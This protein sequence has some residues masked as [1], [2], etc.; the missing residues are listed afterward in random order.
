MKVGILTGGG[1]CPGLNAAIRAAAKKGFQLG[2]EIIGI[3]E[4]WKGLIEG[5]F[6][7][8]TNES[9]SGILHRGGTILGSSRTNPF[10]VEG[11]PEKILENF[12]K[13]G[14]DALIAIGGEDTLGVAYKLSKDIPIVGIP[15]TI[16]N[17]AGGTDFCI[18][19]YTAVQTTC[20][21]L[22][23][24]HPTAESH[25][26]V[27]VVE[28]MGRHFGWIATYSGLAG[29]A[30]YI[31]IPEITPDIEGLC[32]TI[33]KRDEYGKNF[34]L[35]VVAEG[36]KIGEEY[37][38]KKAETDAF[39]HVTLGGAGEILAKIIA[40]KTG[41][42]T[43]AINLGHFIRGGSPTAFDRILATRFGLKA[44]E[45]VS[46]K[47]FGKMVSITGNK[48]TTAPLEKASEQK[49]VEKDVYETA[50]VFF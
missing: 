26:R 9:V 6:E 18:G 17:D 41:A 49:E 35:V 28:V 47:E 20:E 12:K 39:D 34:S 36:A 42:E 2:W 32:K 4:G 16:D 24:L 15:K 22:D 13:M 33:E 30:D 45:L 37:I 31:L 10:K 40:E 44:V 43:R 1:D 50:K 23:K 27:M 3:E 21:V 7:T 19:F 29:G 46:K 25:R 38:T 5:K 8:L 14:L 48:I 11:G